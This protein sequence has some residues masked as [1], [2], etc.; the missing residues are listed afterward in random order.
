MDENKKFGEYEHIKAYFR[1]DEC[2]LIFK[3]LTKSKK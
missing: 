2:K 3:K 1:L